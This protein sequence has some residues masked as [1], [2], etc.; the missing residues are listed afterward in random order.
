MGCSSVPS[1]EIPFLHS[2]NNKLSRSTRN[3][4]LDLCL[5]VA[6]VSRA[7]AAKIQLHEAA[8]ILAAWC[9]SISLLQDSS[10]LDLV[11]VTKGQTCCQEAI[12]GQGSLG[13]SQDI[14]GRHH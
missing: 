13:D 11:Q 6:L 9:S 14:R 10:S 7:F 12:P 5:M 8:G 2:Q 1:L 3:Q 4:F